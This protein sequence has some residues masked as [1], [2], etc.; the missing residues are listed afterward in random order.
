MRSSG[1]SR[2]V[3][4]RAAAVGVGQAAAVSTHAWPAASRAGLSAAA[5]ACAAQRCA[6]PLG[7][8][9]FAAAATNSS[10]EAAQ[11]VLAADV[12]D[13]GPEVL[14]LVDEVDVQGIPAVARVAAVTGISDAAFLEHLAG[15]GVRAMPALSTADVCS[16]AESMSELH[17]YNIA[18]KDAMAEHVLARLPEFSGDQLGKTLR[19]FGSMHYYD[20]DLLEG[21]V[22]HIMANPA[23]FSAGARPP[24]QP[25]LRL[26][27]CTVLMNIADVAYAF[28]KCGFCHPDLLEVVG[29]AA[30]KLLEEAEEDKGETVD[31]LVNWVAQKPEMFDAACLAKTITAVVRLGYEDDHLLVP[32]LNCCVDKL[33]ELPPKAIVK[34]IICLGDLGY[35]HR[36]LLDTLTDST[37]PARIHEFSSEGLADLVE[38]LNKLGYYN[39]NFMSLMATRDGGDLATA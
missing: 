2:E 39:R 28:S 35:A 36:R 6:R 24:A 15:A 4:A 22:E 13:V 21:V 29:T 7:A 16:L 9:A 30:G 11:R 14:R 38:S 18:F 32:L 8:A 3:A 31:K 33:D 20:D 27:A 25:C 23:K 1:C 19:A 34:M 5:E 17:N 37:I 10:H 12:H 26:P